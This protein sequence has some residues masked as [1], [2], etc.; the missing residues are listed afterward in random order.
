MVVRIKIEI[1]EGGKKSQYAV[2]ATSFNKVKE[3]IISHLNSYAPETFEIGAGESAPAPEFK[4]E[5][6][7]TWL[8]GTDLTSLSQKDKLFLILRNNH[9]NQWVRSQDLKIEYQEIFGEEIKLSSLSTYLGRHYAEGALERKGSR[10][11]REYRLP[12]GAAAMGL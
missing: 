11:Q 8:V 1:N 4:P 10:A 3:A 9:P 7:P 6:L 5:Y 12:E 2:E